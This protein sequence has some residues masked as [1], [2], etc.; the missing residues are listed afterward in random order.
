MKASQER[1]LEINIPYEYRCKN[2]QQN[3]SKQN[4]TK[5]NTTGLKALKNYIP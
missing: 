2:L 1:K 5:Q 4:T 3:T